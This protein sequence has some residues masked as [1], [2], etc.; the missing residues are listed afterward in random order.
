MAQRSRILEGLAQVAA[1]RCGD[2]AEA[3]VAAVDAE[4]GDLRAEV[5]TPSVRSCILY[6]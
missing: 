3:A 5:A 1:D 4:L 6:L 2:W